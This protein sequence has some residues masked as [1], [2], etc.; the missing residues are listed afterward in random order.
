L[1]QKEK[2]RRG[3]DRRPFGELINTCGYA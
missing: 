1:M 2:E 3:K